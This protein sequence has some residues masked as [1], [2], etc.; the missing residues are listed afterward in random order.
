M[1]YTHIVLFLLL[2]TAPAVSFAAEP[3]GAP[4]ATNIQAD[5]MQYDA[6]SQR[7][8]FEGNVHVKR[9]DFDLWSAK[10]TVFLDK[11]N[12]PAKAAEEP[13]ANGTKPAM[14]SMGM[15]AGDID[16]IVA[17]KNVRMQQGT[18]VGTSGKATYTASDGKLVMEDSPLIVDGSNRIEG[19]IINFYTREN[20]S[21]VVDGVKATF[22][23]TDKK[24]GTSSLLGRKTEDTEKKTDT[25][26]AGKR[27]RR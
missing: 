11:S 6:A 22:V 20:R 1:R 23:T 24:E 7:V 5:R 13:D 16:R 10:L 25:D 8:I 2:L 9:P 14:G 18:K 4:V 26:K 3:K 19:R 21:D 27:S 17:E 12:K 15:D